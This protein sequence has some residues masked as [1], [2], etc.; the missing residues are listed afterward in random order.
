[1]TR[2]ILTTTSVAVH[3]PTRVSAAG[4]EAACPTDGYLARLVKY[5]PT[6]FIALFLLVDAVVRSFPSLVPTNVYFLIFAVFLIATP[7]Y[8]AI[9]TRMPGA[10][11]A[12]AQILIAPISFAAWVVGFGGPF[13]QLSWYTPIYGA[14]VALAVT[15]LVGFIVPKPIPVKVAVGAS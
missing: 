12:L 15:L 11:P 10:P 3:A 1:M 14:L 5:I 7:I 8:V 2:R 6:E 13:A 9:I 4:G